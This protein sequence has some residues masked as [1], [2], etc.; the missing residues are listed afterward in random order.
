VGIGIF[1]LCFSCDPD[2]DLM[3]FICELH[4]YSIEIY[5]MYEYELPMSRLSKVV[6]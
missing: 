5:Q 6:V 3:T 2:L 4:P 1:D